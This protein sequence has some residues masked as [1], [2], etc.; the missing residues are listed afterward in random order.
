MSSLYSIGQMNE[1]GNALERSG[2]TP[3]D[4]KKVSGGD[5]LAHLLPFV[6]ACG[7]VVA[8]TQHIIDC[9]ADPFTPNGWTV[10]SHRKDGQ[11]I[12]D[13][14]KIKL[15]LSPNQ[16]DGKRIRG[17]EL[18][19]ELASE[20]VLNANVLDFLLKNPHFIPEEWKR[21]ANDHTRFI[22]FW[23]TVYRS[24]HGRLYV[25]DLYFDGGWSW[26]CGWLGDGWGGYSPAALCAS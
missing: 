10:D 9:D 22:F 11:F 15:H 6:R 12:F 3:A 8:T 5:I 21:D 25:R 20:P 23:G 14:A 16:R 4:V 26:G 7:E 18:R 13:P 1:L 17:N 19:E 2:W 24:P